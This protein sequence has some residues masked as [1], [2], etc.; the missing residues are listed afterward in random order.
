MYVLEEPSYLYF[1]DVVGFVAG[2]AGCVVN[3]VVGWGKGWQ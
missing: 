1:G 3:V 2:F